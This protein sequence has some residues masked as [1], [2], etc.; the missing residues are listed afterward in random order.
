[1]IWSL[2]THHRFHLNF[3]I[4]K[5]HNSYAIYIYKKKIA[6]NKKETAH[7]R[8]SDSDLGHEQRPWQCNHARGGASQA[9][10]LCNP[11]L[12]SRTRSFRLHC[13]F[14]ISRFLI[15]FLIFLSSSFWNY[16]SCYFL[17]YFFNNK[18]Y[19]LFFKIYFKY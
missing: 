14:S 19:F 2:K 18:I 1:M 9:M 8:V 13:S 4:K 3:A 11:K 7:V 12:Q 17:M 15:S 6:V 5:H 16:I 10:M